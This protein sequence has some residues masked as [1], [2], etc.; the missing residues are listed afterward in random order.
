VPLGITAH[1][2]ETSI[3]FALG[4]VVA[5]A[6]FLFVIIADTLRMNARAH[7]EFLV[8]APNII[9]LALGAALFRRVSRQ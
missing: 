3:G 1:R 6:Y 9:F 2:R 8:W 7:P 5:V 4:I